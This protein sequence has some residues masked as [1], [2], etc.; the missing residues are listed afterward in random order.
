MT[1]THV[2]PIS[3]VGQIPHDCLSRECWCKPVVEL[4]SAETGMP[5]PDGCLVIHNDV[6]HP[7]ECYG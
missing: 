7:S 5:Y 6:P 4:T 3:P 2:F 1:D